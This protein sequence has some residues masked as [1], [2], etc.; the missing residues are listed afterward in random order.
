MRGSDAGSADSE[1]ADDSRPLD[2]PLGP[3]RRRGSGAEVALQNP[4]R[5]RNLQADRLRRWL[6][7]LL[8]EVTPDSTSFTVRF[9]DEQEMRRLNR[10]Y[11][12]TDASTDVL[13]F[14]GEVTPEGRHLGDVVIAVPVA[15]RQAEQ[16]GVSPQLELRALL[17]HGVL[18]C[19]GYDHESDSGEMS[20]LER[21][22]RG[23]WLNEGC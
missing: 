14:A 18:H 15:R 16:R 2:P 11:R 13:S 3:E 12:E 19:L 21:R 7:A 17:L 5:Y 4:R 23:R 1:R 22:L 6:E 9:V 20:R 10:S 8:R